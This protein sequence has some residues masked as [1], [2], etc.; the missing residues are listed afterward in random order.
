MEFFSEKISLPLKEK[1]L[2]EKFITM[3]HV[4]T[5]GELP[6]HL[7]KTFDWVDLT[8]S[9]INSSSSNLIYRT[10]ICCTPG[11]EWYNLQHLADFDV[12]SKIYLPPDENMK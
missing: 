7:K 4:D 8:I 6:E 12:V 11:W 3:I 2:Q 5:I 10:W 1:V 9:G